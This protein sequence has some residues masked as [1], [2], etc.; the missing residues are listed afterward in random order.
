M[1]KSSFSSKFISSCR[2][3]LKCLVRLEVWKTSL[4]FLKELKIGNFFVLNI[5]FSCFTLASIKLSSTTLT[6]WHSFSPNSVCTRK[7]KMSGF[8]HRVYKNYDPRAK[9]IKRLAEE[10]FSI[11]GR[12]PLIEVY[13]ICHMFY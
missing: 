11:V 4:A 2:L 3:Y 5:V 6:H 12:D 1:T 8:G 7:R 10:V 9:V 13:M